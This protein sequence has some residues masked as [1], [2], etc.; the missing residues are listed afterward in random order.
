M[1]SLPNDISSLF[2]TDPLNSNNI[3][4]E[5]SIIDYI[6]SYIFSGVDNVARSFVSIFTLIIVTCA[7]SSIC[8]SLSNSALNNAF[9]LC[10]TLCFSIT[11]FHSCVGLA[12]LTSAYIKTL[13]R[14]MNA[15]LPLMSTMGIMSGAISSTTTNC[16]ISVLAITLVEGFLVV[17][18]MPLVKSCLTISMVKPIGGCNLSGISKT[19]KTA[20]TSVSVFVMSILFFLLSAKNVLAQGN[21]S[22]SIKTARF[23]ISS[24]VPIVGASIN[25]ALRTVSSSLGVIK[26]TC[27]IIAIIAIALLMVPIIIHLLLYKLS[28]GFLGSVCKALNCSSEGEILEEADS[29]CGFMLVL[30]ACTCVMFIFA[31]TIFINTAVGVA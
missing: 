11:I 19:I 4:N 27:G 28:F 22:L 9:K 2:P 26:S 3:I 15:F 25:D 21:D 20:F 7:L 6:I 5:K 12:E 24:F 23:A 18:L 16:A 17:C 13:C 1:D 30:V 10:S 31:L 8:N 14:V 29:L